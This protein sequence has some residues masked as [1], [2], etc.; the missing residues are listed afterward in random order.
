[1]YIIIVRY[2]SFYAV[3]CRKLSSNI[4]RQIQE[5]VTADSHR[6]TEIVPREEP[7]GWRGCR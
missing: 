2:R 6:I 1:M 5:D 4:K 3:A 7:Q